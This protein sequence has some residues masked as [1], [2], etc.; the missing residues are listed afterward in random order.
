MSLKF[1]VSILLLIQPTNSQIYV[2]TV[3]FYIIYT[4]TCFDISVSSSGSFTFV[5]CQV[6]K[7]LKIEAVKITVP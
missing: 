3:S 7:V 5:S 2:T 4:A 6:T 1:F